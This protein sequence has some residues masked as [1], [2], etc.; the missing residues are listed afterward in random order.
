MKVNI[1]L[2]ETIK[3]YPQLV[4]RGAEYNLPFLNINN[5]ETI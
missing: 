2:K 3:P 1:C 5:N 4:K